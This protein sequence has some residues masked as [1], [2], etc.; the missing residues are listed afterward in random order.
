[1]STPDFDVDTAT[2]RLWAILERSPQLDMDTR[3]KAI[4]AA[5]A[6]AY[7]RGLEEGQATATNGQK[8]AIAEGP[9]LYTGDSNG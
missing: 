7:Q 9:P 8:R 2:M 1:M 3:W 5:L 6:A 4:E